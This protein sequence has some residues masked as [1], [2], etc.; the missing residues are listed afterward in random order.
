MGVV[1]SRFEFE[2][3]TETP[4]RDV[5][6]ERRLTDGSAGTHEDSRVPDA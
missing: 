6:H 2:R 4:R 3:L 5:H 1:P